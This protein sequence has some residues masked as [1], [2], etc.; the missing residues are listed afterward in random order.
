MFRRT[1]KVDP[2]RATDKNLTVEEMYSLARRCRD[3]DALFRLARR[4][5]VDPGVLTEL[6]QHRDAKLVTVVAM[7]P[8]L[9]ANIRANL[10][11]NHHDEWVRWTAQQW[12]DMDPDRPRITM[13]W[14]QAEND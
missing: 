12:I 2:A 13:A 8:S 14:A 9:P 11:A 4:Q 7:H 10:A 5:D 1:P 3:R 6:A